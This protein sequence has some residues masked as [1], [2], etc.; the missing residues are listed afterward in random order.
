MQKKH[1]G[2]Y[3]I[4]AVCALTFAGAA[5]FNVDVRGEALSSFAAL[6]QEVVSLRAPVVSVAPK[7]EA[8]T[9]TM[10][11]E[12]KTEDPFLW[13]GSDA[14]LEI[15]FDTLMEKNDDTIAWLH[16]PAVGI[17]YPVLYYPYD[18]DYYLNRAFDGSY[19]SAGVIYLEYTNK[20]DFSERNNFLYGHNMGDGSMFGNL[21]TLGSDK[22]AYEEYPYFY[23]Y[24]PDGRI[25]RYLIFAF[26]ETQ[27]GSDTYFVPETDE[28]YDNYVKERMEQSLTEP[29]EDL[30]EDVETRTEQRAS[31]VTMSTCHGGAGTTRRFVVH[32]LLDGI[33]TPEEAITD[34]SEGDPGKP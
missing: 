30:E 31:L 6:E 27:S 1:L 5:A 24:E 3:I 26:Y 32:G 33:Y 4:C 14:E 23:L 25:R 9:D 34:V 12:A 7:Q 18:N 22:E 20:P 8:D 29:K 17:S 11:D 16:V 19:S 15:D 10:A 2:L 13:D 21:H 28:A